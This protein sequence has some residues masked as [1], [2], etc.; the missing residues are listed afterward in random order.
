MSGKDR[1]ASTSALVDTK[2]M[3]GGKR[4]R[5]PEALKR[6]L[7]AATFAPGASV[8]IV[9]RRHDVN[10]N[11]LFKWRRQFAALSPATSEPAVSLL[12]VEIAAPPLPP[13]LIQAE[14]APVASPPAGVIEI[15]LRQGRRVRLSGSVDPTVVT[16]VLRVLAR[17]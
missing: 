5:W 12:P 8:S 2:A 1:Q 14:V 4:R 7:V 9:A 13:P 11:Q 3:A 17:R 6:E 15:E 10:A 16:A